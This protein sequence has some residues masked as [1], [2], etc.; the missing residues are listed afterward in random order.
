MYF[1][2]KE[3]INCCCRILRGRRCKSSPAKRSLRS[4]PLPTPMTYVV[5]TP[6]SG[7][8][9]GVQSLCPPLSTFS[10]LSPVMFVASS[11][12]VR[13]RIDLSKGALSVSISLTCVLSREIAHFLESNP[14]SFLLKDTLETNAPLTRARVL[15]LFLACALYRIK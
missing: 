9:P 8:T 2:W 11:R 3:C 6:S 13:S 1:S 15:P 7:R 14:V 4:S 12:R 5:F 10:A